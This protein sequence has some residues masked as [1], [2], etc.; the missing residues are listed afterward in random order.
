MKKG[1]MLSLKV[2]GR[3]RS[4]RFRRCFGGELVLSKGGTVGIK[5]VCG[6]SIKY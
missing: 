2:C 6:F 1:R 5:T 3:Q 4:K